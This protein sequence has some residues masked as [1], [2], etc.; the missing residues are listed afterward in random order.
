MPRP[1]LT[2]IQISK[3]YL[4]FNAAHFT[5]FSDLEREDLHGHTFYVAGAFDAEVGPDGLAFDYNLV[6]TKLKQLCDDLDEKTLLPERSPHLRLT[7]DDG[8]LIAE[9]AGERMPFL[10]RD[11]RTLPIRNVTVEELAPFLLEQLGADPE[12]RALDLQRIELR[13]SS[14]PGQWAAAT[15]T[16]GQSMGEV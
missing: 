1:S 4:H 6:K 14:G 2:S 8:Y 3:E 12:I 7:E 5:L 9:F 10:P 16:E 15:W 13:V 11:V